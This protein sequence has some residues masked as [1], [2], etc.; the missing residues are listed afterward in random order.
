M[1][2]TEIAASDPITKDL[3]AR[4]LPYS[5]LLDKYV[6]FY[7]KSG[8]AASARKEQ[9]SLT[10]TTREL[11]KP[12]TPVVTKPEYFPTYRKILGATIHLDVAR[13]L[14]GFDIPY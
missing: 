12:Y 14:M 5:V 3:V 11:D 6:H 2:F 9:D 13:E 7:Q 8:D 1:T 4:V 10:V